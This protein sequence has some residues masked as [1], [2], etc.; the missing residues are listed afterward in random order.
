QMIGLP[1]RSKIEATELMYCTNCGAK[2]IASNNFCPEC[3]TK[4]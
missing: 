2:N 3:G 1:E 4:L